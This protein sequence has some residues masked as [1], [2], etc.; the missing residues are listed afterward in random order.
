M[1]EPIPMVVKFA[2]IFLLA[3]GLVTT[4]SIYHGISAFD[5]C[6]KAGPSC[7]H[8]YPNVYTAQCPK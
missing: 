7:R 8:C 3:I 6:G 4:T 2:A 5:A 1:I